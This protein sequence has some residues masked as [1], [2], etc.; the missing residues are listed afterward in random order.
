MTRLFIGGLNDT[1]NRGDLEKEFHSFGHIE[2][3]FVARNPPGFGFIVYEKSRDAERAIKEMDGQM[4]SGSRIRVEH[5][6]E[7]GAGRGGGG[8]GGGRGMSNIKCYNCGGFG[9][10]SRD[11]SKSSQYGYSS[12]GG[13]GS[14]RSRSRSRSNERERRPRRRSP[15]R[16][17]SASRERYSRR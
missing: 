9:H 6:R 17:R 15:S 14:R 7:R 3:C 4:I 13:Y 5:A 16:S 1:I 12:R 10:M 2:D 11:C 8:Y